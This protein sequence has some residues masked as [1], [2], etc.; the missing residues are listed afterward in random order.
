MCLHGWV[1][2]SF[3]RFSQQYENIVST[4]VYQRH[5]TGH[6]VALVILPVGQPG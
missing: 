6:S 5:M 4:G 1:L 2:F 3:Q